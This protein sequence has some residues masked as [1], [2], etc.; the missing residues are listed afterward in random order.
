[1]AFENRE[2]TIVG[3]LNFEFE[4]EEESYNSN[5]EKFNATVGI[6]KVYMNGI[7]ITDLCNA[8]TIANYENQLL[9]ELND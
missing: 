7:D 4:H 2:I 9:E 6:K 8:D 3:N 5:G 1:M